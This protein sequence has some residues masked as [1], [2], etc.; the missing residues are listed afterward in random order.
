[1]GK[2]YFQTEY[3]KKT[4]KDRIKECNERSICCQL[5]GEPKEYTAEEHISRH[6]TFEKGDVLPLDYL[7]YYDYFYCTDNNVVRSDIQG[8][9]RD[10]IHDLSTVGIETEN[11]YRCIHSY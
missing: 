9:V 8:T 11:L 2:N 5:F 4:K 3:K 10:L 1:M 7:V 6:C